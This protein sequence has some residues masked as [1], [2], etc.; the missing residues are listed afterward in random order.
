MGNMTDL[1]SSIAQE[2]LAGR[3]VSRRQGLELAGVSGADLHDLFYWANRIRLAF[4]GPNVLC[5]GIV[6][7]KVGSCEQNC[8]FCSQSAHFH[9]HIHGSS[10]LDV[11][12]VVEAA[13]QA[14]RHGATCFGLVN[15]GLGP[16]D[17]EIAWLAPAV[18]Q[19]R[20]ETNLNLCASYGVLTRQQARRLAE[21]GVLRYNHNLQTS[22]RFFPQVCTTHTYDQRVETIRALN[23]A[24][25]QP[26]CGGLFGMGETWEDRVDLALQLREL[27]VH[28]VPINF[29]IPIAGTPM[30]HRPALQALECL[31]I[32]ALFRF[33]LPHQNIQ[34]AGGREMHLRDL[35]S[36]LFLAGANGFLIGNYLTTSGRSA[37]QDLQMLVD[38][39]LIDREPGP[40]GA[41]PPITSES[42]GCHASRTP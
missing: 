17:R 29:L 25:I 34:V 21:L 38:L 33:L 40:N 8:G 24:G 36:W 3:P 20:A 31:Q 30:E 11:D 41:M 7:P 13:R 27:N 37:Q 28:T 15:S 32:I 5:C 6:A 2:V 18:R 19:I 1:I 23:E 22:R 42:C 10:I 12:A 26:C 39:G 14:A 9:T 16:T 4:I 35:Q